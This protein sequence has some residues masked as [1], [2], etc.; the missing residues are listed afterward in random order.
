M[1]YDT[2]KV[3]DLN[4]SV[5]DDQLHDLLCE[6]F[7]SFPDVNINISNRD[8][9]RV[10][11][12]YF[13]S[14]ADARAALKENSCIAM[15]G[16]ACRALPVFDK[17]E[18]NESAMTDPSETAKHV[19]DSFRKLEEEDDE[20]ASVSHD[21]RKA[22]PDRERGG[23]HR[24]GIR[25]AGW[26]RRRGGRQIGFASSRGRG[27]GRPYLLT[28]ARFR[29]RGHR[30]PYLLTRP[31]NK[32]DERK[33]HAESDEDNEDGQ[34][35]H[36]SDT[37]D[38]AREPNCTL[39]IGS[40]DPSVKAIDLKRL[41]NNFGYVLDVE[42]KTPTSTSCFAFVHFLTVDMAH[43]A[44]QEMEGKPIGRSVPKLGFGRVVE[45]R[46]LWIGGIGSWTSEDALRLELSQFGEVQKLE[47]PKNR[48]YAYVLFGSMQDAIDAKQVMHGSHHGDPPHRL[49]VSYSSHLQMNSPFNYK[50][51]FPQ[52]PRKRKVSPPERRISHDR[53]SPESRRM[54]RRS[55]ERG[56]ISWESPQSRHQRR[57]GSSDR[58]RVSREQE[59]QDTH[60]RHRRS[61]ER[62]RSRSPRRNRSP[63]RKSQLH[64]RPRR[65]ERSFSPRARRSPSPYAANISPQ[66]S[67][68]NMSSISDASSESIGS[69]RPQKRHRRSSGNSLLR[70]RSPPK[71]MM[72]DERTVVLRSE[73]QLVTP[74]SDAM[75]VGSRPYS[76]SYVPPV[77]PV[78][79]YP[80]MGG[81]LP[82]PI[83]PPPVH[84]P[85]PDF[86]PQPSPM[87]PQFPQ[88]LPPLVSYPVGT[89][90]IQPMPVASQPNI[91]PV[92]SSPYLPQSTPVK[93][94][95][96]PASVSVAAQFPKVWSGALVLRNAAFVVDFHLLSGSVLLVNTLLGSHVEPGSDADCPVLKITQRLR[97]DQP[98]KLDEL[99]QRLKKV[100]RTGC[101]V[102]L[103]KSAPAQ[104]DDDANVV[105][106]YPL[107]NLVS[108]LLQKQVAAIVSLPPSSS[109]AA[110][111]S[112][113]LHAFPPCQFA[114]AF[115]RKEAPGL[116][117]DCPTEEELLVVLCEF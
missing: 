73:P 60:R 51:D 12:L 91:P 65:R 79:F 5:P 33:S 27:G 18:D 45:S 68:D 113:V 26:L 67:L 81:T 13:N 30:R 3:I 21:E 38:A 86:Y 62:S 56:H 1:M 117:T 80:R 97:L 57:R 23:Y 39:Y 43:L 44:K 72:K 17:P 6:K 75:S 105:Q 115:L 64:A 28:P 61:L 14:P 100:G 69:D 10:A 84:I 90:T 11:Y 87:M 76:S 59:F 49:R 103:A 77:D 94:T 111:A 106:Q 93:E 22:S 101:S 88:H 95:P 32:N 89:D 2:I 98:G 8:K 9:N 7:S 116:P 53:Q 108:Y 25:G 31:G 70:N 102:L 83:F 85:P 112:G 63:P 99:E 34:K 107:S 66:P 42:I 92:H 4:P 48:D 82:P 46:Y 35:P 96:K 15:F 52:F 20:Q 29:G 19:E 36:L 50:H 78:A 47:W 54:R 109:D 104:V 58:G 110:K 71:S 114:T 24:R 37:T 55:P 40:M 16:Y 74:A 41:F